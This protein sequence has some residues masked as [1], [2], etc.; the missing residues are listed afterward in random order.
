MV[1][2]ERIRTSQTEVAIAY[3][4]GAQVDLVTTL[5]ALLAAA[6]IA[7]G[8]QQLIGE[9]VTTLLLEG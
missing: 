4:Y 5:P 7:H 8:Q 2:G 6:T 1:G 3:R 9:V